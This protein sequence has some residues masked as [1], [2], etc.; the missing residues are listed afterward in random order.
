[1]KLFKYIPI[2]FVLAFMPLVQSCSIEEELLDTPTPALIKNEQ[3]VEAV[4]NGLYARFNDASAF[5]FQGMMML[6]LMADDLYSSAGSEYGAYGNRTLSGGNTNSFWN[7]F[8]FSIA[9][10]NAL[11]KTL[12]ELELDPDFE[13]RAYG[14]AHFIRAFS[15]YYLV[16]MWGGVPLRLNA[17]DINSDFYLPRSSVDQVYNQIFADFKKASESLPLYKKIPAAELGRASKG[18]AQG[19]MAQAYLTYGNQLSLRGQDPTA[20][21]QNAVVYAD[22]VISSN[23]YTLISNFKSLF[24]L[25]QEANAYNEVLF[26]IRFQVDQQNRAQPAAGSEFALRFMVAN[27]RGTTGAPNTGGG[28]QIRVMPWFGDFYRTGDYVT[29][30]PGDVDFQMDFRNEVSF[31]TRGVNPSGGVTVMYPDGGGATRVNTPLVG[32]Y[33]DPNGKDDR[34]HGN[35]FFIIRFAEIFLIKAEAENELNGPT[36]AAI[37]AFNKVRDRARK[38]DGT[39]R[40]VPADLPVA[41]TMTKADFRMKIFD[42]RGLELLGEGQRWFDL[43]RMQHPQDPTKTMYEHQFLEELRKPKYTTVFPA[44][45]TANNAWSTSNAVYEN[46]LNVSVP[47][48]LLFPIPTNEILN[49]PKVGVQN[50]NTGW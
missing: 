37:N 32:K 38:A 2:L 10:A 20:Q 50:Q 24:D 8:Y 47:K 45:Q 23:Q 25:Q 14:E 40:A 12:D 21:Y 6:T 39:P 13:K 7:Q 41:T 48:F 49:N 26:G 17:T 35:D 29:G 5:K 30:T 34:N 19:L 22:S 4:I 31:Y 44:W 43:V 33:I 11:I 46:A 9:S 36:A 27:T 3:D 1:M 42:E 15:Y 16:R 28:G 18:A